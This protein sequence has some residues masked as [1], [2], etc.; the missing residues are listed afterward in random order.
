[1]L[2]DSA[3][4]AA[5]AGSTNPERLLFRRFPRTGVGLVQVEGGETPADFA[6]LRLFPV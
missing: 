3:A 1:M 5:A 6:N 4:R 2:D